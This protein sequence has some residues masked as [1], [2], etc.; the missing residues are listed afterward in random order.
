MAVDSVNR[1]QAFGVAGSMILALG[2]FAPVVHAPILGSRNYFSNGEGDGVVI[3]ILALISLALSLRRRFEWLWMTGGGSLA[4]LILTFAAFRLR[5]D[6]LRTST[7]RE[8]ANNPFRA[9]GETAVM[10]VQVEW[11]WAVLIFGACLLLTAAWL[12]EAPL[13]KCP[14]CAE[15]IQ[16]QARVCRYCG[17]DVPTLE[18]PAA[19]PPRVPRRVVIATAVLIAALALFVWFAEWIAFIVHTARS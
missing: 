19:P 16:M 8:L 10:S 6:E 12:R 11:G 17:R 7:S 4:L 2:V 15:Q 1:R 13:Q 9:I 18:P 5:L 14:H 3:L